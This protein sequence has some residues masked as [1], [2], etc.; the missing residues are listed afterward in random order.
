MYA[1]EQTDKKYGDNAEFS[2]AFV[3]VP[4][5]SYPET[6]NAESLKWM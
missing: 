2:H 3:P 1:A 6:W 4:V 5:T